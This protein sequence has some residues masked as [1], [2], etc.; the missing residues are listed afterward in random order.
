MNAIEKLLL[1]I[2]IPC[3]FIIG[4]A[5]IKKS[6]K[7]LKQKEEVERIQFELNKKKLEVL[8]LQ[9]KELKSKGE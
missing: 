8:K 4:Y 7:E 3:I 6:A 1:I 2:V 5:I 9:E